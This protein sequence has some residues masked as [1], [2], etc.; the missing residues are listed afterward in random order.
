LFALNR[1]STGF[2][3]CVIGDTELYFGDMYKMRYSPKTDQKYNFYD[4]S[5]TIIFLEYRP[6]HKQI[7]AVNLNY[8]PLGNRI[9]ICEIIEAIRKKNNI[10][11]PEK[12][13]LNNKTG[14]LPEGKN[15]DMRSQKK[16]E[17]KDTNKSICDYVQV[18]SEDMEK[19]IKKATEGKNSFEW[20]T[21]FKLRNENVKIM[22]T[23]CRIY[24]ISGIKKLKNVM[25]FSE[26][27]RYTILTTYSSIKGDFNTADILKVSRIAK[28]NGDWEQYLRENFS[29]KK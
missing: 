26:E 5:P 17:D 19:L 28:E 11:I 27:E 16:R 20:G 6:A 24:S 14:F 25:E 1:S 13:D 8:V 22:E 23:A 2:L 9:Y 29:N 4:P 18:Y 21:L 7:Y 15:E 12:R 10:P 3:Y